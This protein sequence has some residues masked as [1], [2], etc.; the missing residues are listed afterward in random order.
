VSRYEILVPKDPRSF[1]HTKQNTQHT[2]TAKK[3]QSIIAKKI[4]DLEF[5]ECNLKDVSYVPELSRNLLSV[6]RITENGGEVLFTKR[7]VQ[8]FRTKML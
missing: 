4:G 2:K 3:T 5:K 8:I 7:K 1:T 6:H